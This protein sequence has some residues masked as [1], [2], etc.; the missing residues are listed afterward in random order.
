MPSDETMVFLEK[1]NNKYGLKNNSGKTIIPPIYDQLI[2]VYSDHIW[3]LDDKTW[4]II[5][6]DNQE[7]FRLE[8]GSPCGF[9]NGISMIY[10]NGK[11]GFITY[12][13]NWIC[14]PVYEDALNFFKEVTFVKKNELWA[15]I[16]SKGVLLTG[17]DLE[18][19]EFLDDEK[20]CVKKHDGWFEMDF[21]G[22]I[23]NKLEYDAIE[24]F[25]ET[26][27]GFLK[28]RKN[29]RWGI[30]DIHWKTICSFKFLSLGTCSEKGFAA[31]ENIRCKFGFVDKYG[32]TV[33]PFK[34]DFASSFFNGIGIIMQNDK[35]GAVSAKGQIVIP[36][37]YDLLL[38][39]WAQIYAE[40]DGYYF[41][42][43]HNGVFMPELMVDEI[44][45][46]QI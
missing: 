1:K 16:S 11:H 19:F 24:C 33:I 37:A 2:N 41:Y 28:V 43:A 45:N 25:E 8:T 9:F 38:D 36:L 7:I 10:E 6:L 29:G 5:N 17:F 42:I 22:E 18:K 44:D 26:D 13:G 40:K 32:T 20:L 31:A 14:K 4:K 12:Q 39:E 30:V 3:A 27:K 23:L 35:Y 21:S 34:Y 46:Y 15:L